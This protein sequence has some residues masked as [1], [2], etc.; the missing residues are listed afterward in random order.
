MA[1]VAVLQ[2]VVALRLVAASLAAALRL[3]VAASPAVEWQPHREVAFH[4][5]LMVLELQRQPRQPAEQLR[6]LA[7]PR[8]ASGRQTP[9]SALASPALRCF[10]V[11][12]P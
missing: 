7:V 3:L 2:Q 10:Q 11:R 12:E 8:L 1:A 9:P 4:Y 5:S 6:Q